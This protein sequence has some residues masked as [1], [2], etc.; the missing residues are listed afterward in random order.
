MRA[1][2]WAKYLGKR[3]PAVPEPVPVEA[4]SCFA[5]IP[6]C[7]ELEELPRTFA[8]LRA[9]SGVEEIPVMVVINHPAGACRR[10][11]SASER[12]LEWF[13]RRE[14]TLPR[15]YW[16]YAPELAGGV[17][18]ARKLGMDAVLD[19]VPAERAESAVL[20][21]LDADAW[22]EPDYFEQVRA[23]FAARSEREAGAVSIGLRHRPGETPEQEAAIRAY[24]HYLDRY[25]GK[26]EQAGSPY[27][28][29]TVGSAFAVRASTYVRCGG[30]RVRPAGEDFYFL[31]AASKVAPVGRIERVL[32]HPSPRCSDRVPFGTGRSVRSLLDGGALNEIPDGAFAAL[33]ELLAWSADPVR[34]LSG[35]GAPECA[36]EF[37]EREGFFELW[38]KVLR[39]TPDRDDA[40]LAAFHRWFDGLRTLRFLHFAGG[41]R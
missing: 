35:R 37:F 29:R 8:S 30:M 10:V 24:E 18:A 19:A 27:A 4:A 14:L 31:Q 11:V 34:L 17:G 6:A 28:F 3:S 32:V 25:A 23:F 20:C 39:N 22:V 36:S 15:L 12:M 7:D 33:A 16:I 40:R 38:P 26:L 13:R 9:A 2:D 41:R 21:S 1:A 5:V